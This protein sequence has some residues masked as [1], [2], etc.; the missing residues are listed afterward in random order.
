MLEIMEANMEEVENCEK[1]DRIEE[2]NE[3]ENRM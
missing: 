2:G 3:N 1:Q